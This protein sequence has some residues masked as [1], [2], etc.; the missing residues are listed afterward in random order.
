MFALTLNWFFYMDWKTWSNSSSSDIMI[1]LVKTVG[2]AYEICLHMLIKFLGHNMNDQ[3]LLSFVK[4]STV[5]LWAIL[6]TPGV[7]KKENK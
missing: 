1:K 6:F 5:Y 7:G 2:N 4:Y 3:I